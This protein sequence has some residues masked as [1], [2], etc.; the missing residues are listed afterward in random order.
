M[1][2]DPTD[3]PLLTP[4][5]RDLR[6]LLQR[7]LRTTDADVTA[8]LNMDPAAL[9]AA[10]GVV[11]QIAA[12]LPCAVLGTTQKAQRRRVARRTSPQTLQVLETFLRV[13]AQELGP[14]APKADAVETLRHQ[15]LR[16]QS[17]R[18][19]AARGLL[20]A[21]NLRLVL[22][23]Y[24]FF[25]VNGATQIARAHIED[26]GTPAAERELY[27]E[28]LGT[29]LQRKEDSLSASAEG[30]ADRARLHQRRVDDP[31][32]AVLLEEALRGAEG[33]AEGRDVLPHEED[34]GVPFHLLAE[35]PSDRVD[36]GRLSHRSPPSTGARTPSPPRPA[37]RPGASPRPAPA[38]PSPSRAPPRPR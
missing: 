17:L 14:E 15:A 38:P 2:M 32:P 26:P 37:R 7:T 22:M 13:S 28:K 6:G 16:Y 24:G 11:T 23:A 5:P 1:K 8:A 9:R 29:L 10:T 27:R 21:N 36:V 20:L 35:G 31:Q 3:D 25:V 18:N 19:Q 30:R 12:Q 34:A 33:P 4:R